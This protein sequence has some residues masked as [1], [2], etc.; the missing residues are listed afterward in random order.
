LRLRQTRRATLDTIILL[1]DAGRA[2]LGNQLR[3]QL[4]I[5]SRILSRHEG[6]CGKGTMF[7]DSRQAHRGFSKTRV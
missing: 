6:H 1:K 3:V 7:N 2:Q 5:G 4:L